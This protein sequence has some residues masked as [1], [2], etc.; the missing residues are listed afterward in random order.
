LYVARFYLREGNFKATVARI[1][2]AIKAYPNSGL[3]P[4]ALV[5]LGE[6]YLKMHRPEEARVVL[7]Q[8]VREH[9]E[10]AFVVPAQKFIK[11]L[12]PSTSDR[13]ARTARKGA[14]SPERPVR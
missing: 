9:G 2:H 6:T 4:E 13:A 3:E 11:R 14:P 12:P 10:S 1:R 8:V 5:L 7:H